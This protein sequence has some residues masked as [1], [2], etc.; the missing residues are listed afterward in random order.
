MSK[1][2]KVTGLNPDYT[3]V[4]FELNHSALMDLLQEMYNHGKEGGS[5]N[6]IDVAVVE[7]SPKEY[8]K[9]EMV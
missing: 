9:L 1:Y 4:V 5:F 2:I 6:D 7:M 8:S 3:F